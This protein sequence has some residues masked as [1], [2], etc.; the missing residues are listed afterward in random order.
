MTREALAALRSLAEALPENQ[1][2][3]VPREWLLELL[4]GKPVE[5]S[6]AQAPTVDLTCH[7]VAESLGRDASTVRAWAARGEFPGAYRLNG[8]EWR[9]PA[10]SLH[11]WQEGQRQ[12]PSK[13]AASI[14]PG[15]R[16]LPLSSWRSTPAKLSR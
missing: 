6:A 10:E 16:R 7:Q 8:R 5:S 2:V 12:R 14:R 13:S 4:G 1:A 11:A 15:G 3:P 9:I